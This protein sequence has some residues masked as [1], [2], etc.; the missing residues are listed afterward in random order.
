MKLSALEIK[1]QKFARSLRGYDIT[2]VQSFLNVVS[3]EWEHLTARSRDQDREIQRLTEK[4]EH[5]QKVEEALHETL[6]AAKES[7]EQRIASSK[8]EAQNRIAKAELEAEKII[9]NAQQER[10]T[11]RQ[12]IQRLLE[13]RH[14]IIRGME[15]Y[16]DL[17]T[18]SLGSFKRDDAATYTLPDD[19]HTEQDAQS[20]TSSS[21]DSNPAGAPGKP[22]EKSRGSMPPG[23][24]DLDDLIDDLE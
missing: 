6:Q 21:H 11:I 12:S 1:Q 24:E 16:L 15:S 17:A 18:E 20:D 14:E 13:R 5:Y 19:T 8:Q 23:V 10:Q 2:E 7:S 9:R 3:N 22:V 4:L